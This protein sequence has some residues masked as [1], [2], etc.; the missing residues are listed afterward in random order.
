MSLDIQ[1]LSSSCKVLSALPLPV[2]LHGNSGSRL[3]GRTVSHKCFGWF[4]VSVM[5]AAMDVI[6][7]FL[8]YSV[9]FTSLQL[10][11][12]LEINKVLQYLR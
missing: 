2:L 10:K 4:M 1:Q 5:E 9:L 3:T 11:E 7:S 8:H 12:V 6:L